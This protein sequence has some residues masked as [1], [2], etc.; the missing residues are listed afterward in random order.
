MALGVGPMRT[1]DWARAAAV[2]VAL[3]LALCLPIGLGGCGRREAPD[4][5]RAEASAAATDTEEEGTPHSPGWTRFRDGFVEGWFRLDPAYAVFQGR[6]DYDGRL[7][8]WSAAGL[9]RQIAFL[10]G[11][12]ARARAFDAADL[13]PAE[14]F[15]RDYLVTVARGRLFW[16][17]EADQ[18]HRNPAWYV[19]GGLDPNVYVMR[20]YADPVTR[21]KALTALLRRIPDAAANIRA[22]LKTP[23]PLAHVDYSVTTFRGF[24]AYYMDDSVKAFAVVDDDDLQRDLADAAMTASEAM[25]DLA[26]WAEA[27]RPQA[28]RSFAL[29]P[30]LFSRMLLETEAVDTPLSALE[31]AGRAELLRNQMA[32]DSACARFAPGLTVGACLARANADKPEDGPVAEARR[33]IPMLRAF[34]V[35]HDLLTIR[36]VRDAFVPGKADL[37]FTS[38][39]EAMPGHF[40]QFVRSNRSRSLIGRVFVGY[41]YAEGWAHYAEE[42]MWEAGLNAGDAETH[43][44]QLSNALLRN[45]RYLAAIGLH[46]RRM[47]QAEAF[48]LFVEQCHQDEGNARQQA[49]RGTYDPA[50]LNYTM[51]KLLIRRLRTDWTATRGGRRAW[52]AFHDR[53]LGYGGPPIPLVRQAMMGEPEPMAVF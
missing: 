10:H 49:L 22:N 15:E 36:A 18:P 5:P 41:A 8:D 27:Q 46:A 38:I 24:A 37:L 44:G 19:A 7:A 40:L 32:L 33:Q 28:T 20:A 35:S 43:I 42:M 2:R 4:D 14:R 31:A 12:I 26:E 11:A 16:L 48:R 21:M 39:H 30:V 3:A 47:T 25:R 6:H 52:K 53:L 34:V 1:G 45:C 50:Y 29:G 13:Q 23:M 9:A 17:E 51:G